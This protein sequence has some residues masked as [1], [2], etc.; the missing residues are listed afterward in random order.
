MFILSLGQWKYAK[1]IANFAKRRYN[2]KK[3][4]R[5][6]RV[7]TTQQLNTEQVSIL[8]WLKALYD[9]NG[10]GFEDSSFNDK[11][12]AFEAVE[13]TGY[14]REEY[15]EYVDFWIANKVINKKGGKLSISKQGKKLFAL[16][17]DAGNE[18]DSEIKNILQAKLE[19]TPLDDIVDFVKSHPKE[20][21]DIISVCIQGAEI[22][23][24]LVEK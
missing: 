20:I 8:L 7:G 11:Y 2:Y 16:I 12:Y 18:E 19:K 9:F 5:I 4:W 14:T 21:I 6:K 24:G 10:E 13:D 23:I 1:S 22:V 3:Y 15:D 17:D